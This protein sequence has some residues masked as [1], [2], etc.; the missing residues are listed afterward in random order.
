MRRRVALFVSSLRGGGA[1][2]A[3]LDIARGLSQRGLAVDLVLAKAS[4]PYLD[5]VPPSVRVIN[6]DSRKAITCILKLVHYLRRERPVVLLSTMP[7]MNIISILVRAIFCRSMAVAVRR[8]ANFSMHFKY[9]GFKDRVVLRL[10]KLLLR[11]SDVVITNSSAAA[12]DLSRAAP[13]LTPIIRVI[14]NPVVW[15][16]LAE[17][18]AESVEHTWLRRR[19]TPVILAAGRLVPQKDYPTLLKAFGRVVLRS[20][21]ARLIVLGEGPDRGS[22]N[23]L[24]EELGVGQAVDFPGFIKNPF[25]YMSKACAFVMSSTFEGSPNVLV[26][27]MACGTPVVSTDC[28]SGP[29]EILQDGVLGRLVPVGDWQSLGEAILETLESPVDSGKL[30]EGANVYAAESSIQQYLQLVTELHQRST[31]K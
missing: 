22:L 5:L 21:S 18:A 27:A 3:M 17:Q 8:A 7:T 4:G 12:V 10:E 9:G 24:T 1:E 29:R 2:R 30:I 11:F 25:A 23:A 19:S 20:R 31:G 14:Y 26:Q 16:D 6:L 28:P 15:P 13:P